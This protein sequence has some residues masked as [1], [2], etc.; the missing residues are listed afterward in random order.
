MIT[1]DSLTKS[2]TVEPPADSLFTVGQVAAAL[3]LSCRA[4][5]YM[6]KKIPS[7]GFVARGEKQVNAWPFRS[8]P[9]P[10]QE[11]LSTKAARL[12]F[13]SA[14]HLLSTQHAEWQPR[15]SLKDIAQHHLE[16]AVKL[17]RALAWTL[18]HIHDP[19]FR[20]SELNEQGLRGYA[21]EFGH[22]ISLR[23]FR[24]LLE[25][26]LSRDGGLE[27]WSRLEIYLDDNVAGK[28][29]PNLLEQLRSGID[30]HDLQDMIASFRDP[31]NPNHDEKT[32][33]WSQAFEIY[34]QHVNGGRR[35]KQVQR[36]L[37]NFLLAKLPILAK[38]I[39]SLRK[40]FI[41]KYNI[42]SQN[43]KRSDVISDKRIIKSGNRRAPAITE[44]DKEI[45]TA[46][47]LDCGGRLAQA[48]RELMRE[49]KLSGPVL[50]Y[51][52]SNP[53]SKSYVPR[54][55]RD[56]MTPLVNSLMPLH[57]GPK[58]ART[59]GAYVERDPSS[60]LPWDWFQGDD[61]TLPVY[62]YEETERG[63]EVMRG[64]FLMM[65]DVA[66]MFILGFVLISAPNYRALHIRNLM[67]MVHDEYGLPNEG[68]YFEKGPWKSRLIVG[69]Q[70]EV[71]WGQ[72][73]SG[74]G[75]LGLRFQHARGPQA[76]I[77]ERI[78]GAIQNSMERE[79]CYI[80]RD[81]RHDYF[82]RS[83]KAIAEV[84]SGNAHPTEV[85]I[86]SHEQWLQRLGKICEEFNDEPQ[87]GKYLRGVSPHQAFES[88]SVKC[89]RK[90]SN[91]CRFL[92]ASNILKTRVGRNG[93]SIRIGKTRYTY[94]SRE[95]G[96]RI[97]REVYLY[98]N[99]ENP[100]IA[101]FVD[102]PRVLK[103]YTVERAQLVPAMDA[104]GEVLEQALGQNAAHEAPCREYYRKIK[105][106]FSASFL[107]RMYRP[108]VTDVMTA[109]LGETMREQQKAKIRQQQNTEVIV[110][111]NRKLAA[112]VGLHNA[113]FDVKSAQ[114]RAGLELMAEALEEH[115]LE[116]TLKP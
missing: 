79:P 113:R 85:G 98:F 80:G 96:E 18:A 84:K 86:Y 95:T 93:I 26:T 58:W 12:G 6:L 62:Y 28:T 105:H 37:L 8:F 111:Q 72:T 29:K 112:R 35:R 99:P 65:V 53:A 75:Q 21:R 39:C 41:R 2:K 19:N 107:S 104:S 51:Y 25:R 45:L 97:G 60:I 68:F 27:N 91:E 78:F 115:K 67:S 32:W 57:H 36:I 74:L 31:V 70:D 1:E 30:T 81:E 66:T 76:K 47:A 49:R 94:K 46:R 88:R 69:G 7:G 82:E 22:S 54:I 17:Q 100:D 73:E 83:Q 9:L 110:Q 14:E 87:D 50:T 24:D 77:I 55:I 102:D 38:N 71:P 16:K 92:M 5:Y 103:P 11:Q 108:Y 34:D 89:G 52:L 10:Y 116:E 56:K 61:S 42:W 4:V 64:Q 59:R 44:H 90:L 43:N 101:S 114:T 48:W 23:H 33:L 3:L 63:F 20:P 109:N 40:Q 13:R 106:H 15:L